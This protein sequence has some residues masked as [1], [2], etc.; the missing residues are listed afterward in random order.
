MK[1]TELLKEDH[2]RVA[3]L[4]KRVKATPKG[5]HPALFAQIN[6]ELTV[7]THIEEVIFYPALL[8]QGDK[9]LQDITREGIEE[10][11]Q[12]KMFL[13]ELAKLS[14]ANKQYEA[15]LTVLMEDI[16]HHVK[17]EESDMFNQAD[18]QLSAEAQEK[19][20]A[21]MEKEKAKLV[22]TF[23][24]AQRAALNRSLNSPESKGALATAVDKAK[25]LV[26]DLLSAGGPAGNGRAAQTNGRNGRNAGKGKPKTRAQATKKPGRSRVAKTTR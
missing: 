24:P 8:K 25:E 23:P 14:P 15:K 1:A 18:D 12:A 5:E 17:E 19:L 3:N 4:F 22:A 26:T 9:P 21:R 11:H 13:G 6:A 20:G 10:H 16:E 2:Q 7:H